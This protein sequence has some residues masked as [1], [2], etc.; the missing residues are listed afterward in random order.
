MLVSVR[1]NDA[2]SEWVRLDTG[3]A[4]ALQWV[5]PEVRPGA[6]TGRLAVGLAPLSLAVTQ[7]TLTLGTLQF[8]NVPTD[9]QQQE[10]FPGEKGLLGNGILSR[11]KAITID[12]RSGRLFL[13]PAQ[14]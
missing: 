11:C 1:V 10:S 13:L 14:R 8:R 7:T 3:C 5:A 4:S 12:A 9:L 6:H 2:P